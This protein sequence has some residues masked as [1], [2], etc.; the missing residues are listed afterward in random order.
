MKII[1]NNC[2][3]CGNKINSY[4]YWVTKNQKDYFCSEECYKKIYDEDMDSEFIHISTCPGYKDCEK[5]NNIRIKCRTEHNIS[6]PKSAFDNYNANITR[7]WCDP[8]QLSIIRTNVKT[9]EFII[10]SQNKTD[11]INKE[12]IKLSKLNVILA[13]VMIGISLINLIIML[14]NVK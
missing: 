12:T 8:A 5:L 6:H 13:I 14:P 9:Y 2:K 1:N 11:K 7:N 3:I 4:E 10:D